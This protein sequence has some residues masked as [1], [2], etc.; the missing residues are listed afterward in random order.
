M[1][2]ITILGPVETSKL[3]AKIK[4][5]ATKLQDRI[6]VAAVSCL[7]HIRDHGDYTLA[8]SLLDALPN[9]QRVKALG[10]WFGHFSNGA[11][12]FTIKKGE[13]WTCKLLKA[14]T[15]EMFD[16]DGAAAVSF[17]DLTAE[18]EPTTMTAQQVVAM[19]KRKADNDDVNA[20]G[21]PKVSP[22]ARDLFAKLW[23]VASQEVSKAA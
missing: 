23:V 10:H 1:S 3:I 20:D 8:I 21:T 11:A 16:I 12:T 18:K 17:A 19:L 7:A 2:T 5:S 4:L 9:G 13:G 14:R 22:E 6:H 15:P